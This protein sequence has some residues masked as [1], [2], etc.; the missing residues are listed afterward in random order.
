MP[1]IRDV[2]RSASASEAPSPI[3]EAAPSGPVKQAEHDDCYSACVASLL[4]LELAE[5]PKFYR[6]AGGAAGFTQVPEVFGMIREWCRPR[7]IAPL[8]LPVSV[9]LEY[10]LE[11][12]ER[13]NPGVPFILSGTSRYGTGHSVIACHG[14]IIHEPMPGYGPGDGGVAAPDP[15]GQYQVTYFTVLPSWVHAMRAPS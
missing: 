6:E 8:F 15:D 5:V 3:L 13:L 11:H 10:L 1:L 4:G 2:G 7:G 14:R 9:S 12:T